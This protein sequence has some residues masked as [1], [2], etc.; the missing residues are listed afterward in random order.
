MLPPEQHESNRGGRKFS[1]AGSLLDLR[2]RSSQLSPMGA[3]WTS[4]ESKMVPGYVSRL[5]K[6]LPESIILLVPGIQLSILDYERVPFPSG[7]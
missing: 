7:A 2:R 5:D 4:K 1:S 6:G 3:L